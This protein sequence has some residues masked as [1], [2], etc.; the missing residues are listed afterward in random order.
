MD[1]FTVNSRLLTIDAYQ[2]LQNKVFYLIDRKIFAQAGDW[3]VYSDGEE[4][5]PIIIPNYLFQQIFVIKTDSDD[6]DNFI[7]QYLSI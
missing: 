6:M 1:K 3:V 2:L 4:T 5:N 7:D